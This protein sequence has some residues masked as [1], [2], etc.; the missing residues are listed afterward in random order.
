MRLGPDTPA[1]RR[2]RR[3]GIQLQRRSGLSLYQ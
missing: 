1:E 3:K 2:D